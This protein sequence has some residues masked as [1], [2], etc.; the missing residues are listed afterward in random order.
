MIIKGVE[1]RIKQVNKGA[2]AKGQKEL[3]AY[4]NGD[5]TF[6]AGAVKAKCYDCNGYY[7]DGRDDC[8]VPLCPLYPFH[9][10]NPNRRRGT[11]V[12]MSDEQKA[13][14]AERL[15]SYHKIKSKVEIHSTEPSATKKFQKG[16]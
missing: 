14:A 13:A 6:L 11:A 10:Y 15:R 9:P 3:L 5:K 2:T 8:A 12:P 4:L 7:S 1:E 16:R